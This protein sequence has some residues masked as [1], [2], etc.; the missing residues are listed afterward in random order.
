MSRRQVWCEH[1]VLPSGVGDDVVIAIEDEL[2]VDVAVGVAPPADS[3]V[4]RGLTLPGFANAHSHAFH[5][6]LR[7]RTH[8]GRGDFWTWREQMYSVAQR[9]TP[10]NYRALARA[11]FAEMVLA[12]FTCVGEFHYV[13][14]EPDGAPYADAN[15][16]GEAVIDAA[17]S[18][19]IRLTLLDACYL[20]SG[21]GAPPL[22]EQRRFSDGTAQQWVD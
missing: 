11:A 1:A 7:G 3:T 2:V 20:R 8:D 16:M 13:H 6:A 9:L 14:H 17:R 10:D 5:R 12:G 18:A 4:L 15:A 22:P 21:A 19:G